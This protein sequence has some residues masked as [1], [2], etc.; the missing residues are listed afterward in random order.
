MARVERQRQGYGDQRDS[1][2]R[3]ERGNK[4]NKKIR[5]SR[6]READEKLAGGRLKK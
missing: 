5:Q 3:A 2:R 4:K 1:E 6:R